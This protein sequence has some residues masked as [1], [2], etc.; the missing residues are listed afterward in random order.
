MH[1]VKSL[2]ADMLADPAQQVFIL[3]QSVGR[4][5]HF[6]LDLADSVQLTSRGRRLKEDLYEL[7]VVNHVLV[8]QT[9]EL[10][11]KTDQSLLIEETRQLVLQNVY[12]LVSM[13]Q[14]SVRLIELLNFV[15]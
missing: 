9:L 5:L 7:R 14:T 10:I 13:D 4:P 1:Q 11:L 12:E 6:K 8:A 15:D 3:I 2:Q